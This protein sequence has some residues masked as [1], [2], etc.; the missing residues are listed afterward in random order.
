MTLAPLIPLSLRMTPVPS[1]RIIRGPRRSGRTTR[2][3][4]HAASLPDP[5]LVYART[6]TQ[7]LALKQ[8]WPLPDHVHPCCGVDLM[9]AMQRVRQ[10]AGAAGK[11]H[12]C[13]DNYPYVSRKDKLLLL[14]M[15]RAQHPVPTSVTLVMDSLQH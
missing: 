13:V 14:G 8:L 5:V 2:L 15:A 6:P 4:Q 10:Q 11:W 3:L 9:P 7:V 12:L 1:A